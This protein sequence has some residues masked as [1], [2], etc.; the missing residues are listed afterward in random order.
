MKKK[1]GIFI[2]SC[3]LLV[4][5]ISLLVSANNQPEKSALRTYEA[6]SIDTTTNFFTQKEDTRPVTIE[7][8]GLETLG[9]EVVGETDYL[10]LYLL[11]RTL[12]IAL[13]DKTT[14]YTWLSTYEKA[15]QLLEDKKITEN[16]LAEV[17]S[18]VTIEYFDAN[19]GNVNPNNKWPY[20][21]VY[22]KKKPSSTIEKIN[23]GFIAH[24]NYSSIGISFDLEVKID[25]KDLFVEVPRESINEVEIEGIKVNKSYQL[26]SIAV[27]PYLGS[28]NYEI[29][30]YSFIPDG[31]GALIRYTDEASSTAFIKK[32]YGADYGVTTKTDLYDHIKESGNVSL[33]IY[34][35][36]HGYN[37]A[38]FLCQIT[39]GAGGAELVSYPYG[40]SNGT[41]NT[42]FFRF[43]TR[44]MYL[45][46]LSNNTNLEMINSENYTYDYSLKYSFLS[47]ENA[48]YVG[49]ANRYREDLGLTKNN[50]SGDISL[51]LD[52]LGVDYKNG[53]FGKDYVTMTT[54]E[55]ALNILKDLK[56][57]G[58]EKINLNYIGWNKGG[59]FNKSAMNTSLHSSLGNKNDFKRLGTYINEN[60]MT[61]EVT[62]NPLVSS[63]YG[64]TN[65]S[66]K[67]LNLSSFEKEQRSSMVQT[68]YYVAPT[69]LSKM[70]GKNDK[71]YSKLG[72]Y[73]LN[74]DNLSDSYSY[75]VGSET[76]YREQ[77]INAL[78]SEL[79]K[80]E[81][82]TISTTS[83]NA[84][85]LKY[86]TNYYS[87][88]YESSK[89]LYETDSIPFISILLSGYVNLYSPQINYISDY[90]LMNLRMVEYNIAPTFIVTEEEAQKLR[91]TNFEYLNST[92]YE[93]WSDLIKD[94]YGK[95]NTSLR[96][97]NG[98]CIV[99]HRFVE[100][101]VA[102]ITYSNGVILYV[103]YNVE[104][105]NNG[106]I[107]VEHGCKVVEVV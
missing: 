100:D 6:Q 35:V 2:V 41:F 22:N 5:S 33:P 57:S 94:T 104:T 91:F 102:E 12:G 77:M 67:K 107:Q 21:Y 66:I 10:R 80:V 71:G 68:G 82:Y 64:L 45:I 56:H 16:V 78:C 30:G 50:N 1:F 93:A 44:D 65:K 83:P 48:N 34:G 24:V 85:L 31:S 70:I 92:T 54:Y 73:G 3:L 75:K 105:Y 25:G 43:N 72:I 18:A 20:T 19:S 51:Q 88:N 17:E 32:V 79:D 59:Y 60:N 29:N 13:V 63:T 62:I 38:A 87:A 8:K 42:T 39:S 28:Q 49:M 36:N 52:M 106:S 55:D 14:G 103:N 37:Q 11:K 9:Y 27:Y 69:E 81:G 95:V 23:N 26:R 40:Y 47:N 7:S 74:I 84:Y 46:E 86:L 4:V 58:V 96:N 53:L 61:M 98:A 101:G 76:Y 15:S 90:D 99:N 97:V 89:Y